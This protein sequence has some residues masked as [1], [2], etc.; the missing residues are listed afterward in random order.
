MDNIIVGTISEETINNVANLAYKIIE[1]KVEKKLDKKKL[2]SAINK[3]LERQKA[4]HEIA[5]LAEEIDF[6]GLM[7]YIS[8][9][10]MDRAC[11]RCFSTNSKKRAA[12]R[13]HIVSSACSYCGAD[14]DEKRAKV[15]MIVCN[16]LDI[17]KNFYTKNFE[18]K[19]YIISAEIVDSVTENC[20]NMLNP[21]KN[22]MMSMNKKLEDFNIYSP[23][24]YGKLAKDGDLSEIEERMD[25]IFGRMSK[26]HPLYPAYGYRLRGSNVFSYPISREAEKEYP[27]CYLCD[28]TIYLGNQRIRNVDRLPEN[29]MTY[30]DQHQ[31]DLKMEL[32]NVVK[33]L[34]D[35]VDPT[36]REAKELE[37]K[38]IV[39]HPKEFP[40]AMP[41]SIIVNEQVFFDYIELR[42]KEIW[43][44]KIVLLDNSEQKNCHVRFS[45]KAELAQNGNVD[46]NIKTDG[47]SNQDLYKFVHFME[48]L[49]NGANIKIKN[50]AED[51]LLCSGIIKVASYDSGF[52]NIKEE[53]S[54][55]K[56]ICDIERYAK[57]KIKIP[58]EITEKQVSEVAYLAGLIRGTEQSFHW[59]TFDVTGTIDNDVRQQIKEMDDEHPQEIVF[60]SYRNMPVFDEFVRVLL[61]RKFDCA[62]VANIEKLK[63]KLDVLD[64]GDFIKLSY[65]SSG[66]GYGA[67]FICKPMEWIKD[68]VVYCLTKNA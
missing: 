6:Q 60:L 31:L 30:A 28:G 2:R 17:I 23:E 16:C 59:E 68:D 4:Y 46:F 51:E 9:E 11:E 47:G 21:I 8:S 44:D 19:D 14:S 43:E 1:K 20:E 22:E 34:G 57:K 58:E 3:Y 50:L 63:R 42:I 53:L 64:D 25:L 15:S 55:L 48:I 45:F 36:Q 24:A 29:I 67:D 5:T 10:C 35:V 56:N 38:V 27:P 37:G 13:D 54:F 62:I 40:P 61:M 26:E 39:R 41:C 7:E 33:M 32:H 52:P 65:Q 66:N 18:I 49:S 12:A